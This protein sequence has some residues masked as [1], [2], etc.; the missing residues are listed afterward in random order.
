MIKRLLI[1]PQSDLI[2]R[3]LKREQLSFLF[4]KKL[5]YFYCVID[6]LHWASLILHRLSVA[7]SRSCG[8]RAFH[9]GGLIAE[10]WPI[11]GAHRVSSCG[12]GLRCS[13]RPNLWL[14]HRQVD[15]IRC[16]TREVREKL[17]CNRY[18]SHGACLSGNS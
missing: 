18:I 14:L 7:E 12:S 6:G 13:A 1:V 17:S 10:R 16:A 3:D 4:L 5:L 9:R 11:V 15:S 2:L 8:G